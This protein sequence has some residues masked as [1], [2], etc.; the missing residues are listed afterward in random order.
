MIELVG[1]RGI[2]YTAQ[3]IAEIRLVLREIARC[4]VGAL[5]KTRFSSTAEPLD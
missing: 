4:S 5:K 2:S 3:R 1:G